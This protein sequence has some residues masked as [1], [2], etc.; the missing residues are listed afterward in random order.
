VADIERARDRWRARFL[1]YWTLKEAYLKARGLG[2]SVPLADIC[3]VLDP[4]IHVGFVGALAGTDTN[5]SFHLLD[6]TPRHLVAVAVHGQ[7]A[8]IADAVW[9]PQ[10]PSPHAR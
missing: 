7:G 10:L 1:T 4:P 8:E 6:P 5:W 3:F 9:T 2:I